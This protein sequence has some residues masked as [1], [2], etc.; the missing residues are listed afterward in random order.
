MA[1][2]MVK[3]GTESHVIARLKM[4]PTSCLRS[5]PGFPPA[6]KACTAF[7]ALGALPAPVFASLVFPSL[8][9][10]PSIDSWR[11]CPPL[12]LGYMVYLICPVLSTGLPSRE[13]ARKEG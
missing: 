2:R 5:L 4:T 13:R 12:T 10:Y 9:L 7:S 11:L 6:T 3:P 8:L 1:G